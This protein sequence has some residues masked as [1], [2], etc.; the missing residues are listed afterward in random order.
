[1][2]QLTILGE[3]FMFSSCTSGAGGDTNSHFR[4]NKKLVDDK[5][6]HVLESAKERGFKFANRCY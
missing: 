1:M 2:D 4:I 5:L 3:D 6:I